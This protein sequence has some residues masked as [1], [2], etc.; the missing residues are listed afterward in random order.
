MSGDGSPT[1]GVNGEGLRIAIVASSWHDVVMDGLIAGA[2][3]ACEQASAESTVLRV[4]GSFEL[5]LVAQ[6]A[7][8]RRT[9]TRSWPWAW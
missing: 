1:I 7:C 9:S 5:P 6:R 3:R 8:G 4:P 2:L